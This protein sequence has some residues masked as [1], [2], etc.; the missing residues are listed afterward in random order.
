MYVFSV[1]LSD[2]VFEHHGAGDL[3]GER[4][5]LLLRGRGQRSEDSPSVCTAGSLVATGEFATNH[6]GS[7]L[8]FCQVI[9]SIDRLVA[10]QRE[11]MVLL[12]SQAVANLF[13]LLSLVIRRPWGSE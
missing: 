7:Q 12:F 2:F 13:F 1:W 9:G 3:F 5:V 10:E 4:V 6:G 8:S 11:E